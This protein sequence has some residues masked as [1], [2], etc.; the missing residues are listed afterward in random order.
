[1]APLSNPLM[2]DTPD[3]PMVDD[4]ATREFVRLLTV[5]QSDIYLY[6]RSLSLT[7]DE[8]AEAAQ[9]T[10]MTLW[11]KR[12][13]FEA[14]TNFRA[15]AFAIARFKVLNE[16]RKA[17]RGGMRL[18]DEVMAQLADRAESE[19]DGAASQ[20]ADLEYCLAQLNDRDRQIIKHRYTADE[21][22]AHL[23]ERLGRPVRWVYKQVTRI[24][25]TLYEC[26]TQRA[27]GG[28]S[29]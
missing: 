11:E 17:N 13:E 18:S 16:R 25:R 19:L 23:A 14:G 12:G 29:K 5:Y 24:R 8:A 10:S 2:A 6:V 20:M 27:A 9:E 7:T 15:W 26:V 22:T 21:D 28:D 1:M 3:N 4:A